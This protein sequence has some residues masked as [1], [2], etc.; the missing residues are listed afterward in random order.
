MDRLARMDSED[1]G[2]QNAGCWCSVSLYLPVSNNSIDAWLHR[3]R[4]N[5]CRIHKAGTNLCFSTKGTFYPGGNEILLKAEL[6]LQFL[7]HVLRCQFSVPSWH[8]VDRLST[9]IF[10]LLS[11]VSHTLT[12]ATNIMCYIEHV[13]YIPCGHWSN[14]ITETGACPKVKSVDNVQLPCGQNIQIGMANDGACQ[15]CSKRPQKCQVQMNLQV[16]FNDAYLDPLPSPKPPIY[17]I[18]D[19]FPSRCEAPQ[20]P[21]HWVRDVGAKSDVPGLESSPFAT[22]EPRTATHS[23]KSTTSRLSYRFN[24]SSITITKMQCN[25]SGWPT[26]QSE[27]STALGTFERGTLALSTVS[28]FEVLIGRKYPPPQGTVNILSLLG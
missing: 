18:V 22:H 15:K 11:F 6:S 7:Y 14:R 3:G 5:S 26:V 1:T 27:S 21:L 25:L 19:D 13:C 28:K 23:I 17:G 16:E 24:V 12:F 9:L 4:V 8:P 20:E 2:S 10:S